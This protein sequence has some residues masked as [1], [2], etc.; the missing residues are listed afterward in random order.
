M[1]SYNNIDIG[2]TYPGTKSMLL[3]YIDR[4][5][6]RDESM[7][8]Y[9]RPVNSTFIYARCYTV[10]INEKREYVDGHFHNHSIERGLVFILC[11][12]PIHIRASKELKLNRR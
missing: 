10:N 9:Y 11:D 6:V 5:C 1:Y 7:P 3:V 4:I 2:L 12:A 8:N